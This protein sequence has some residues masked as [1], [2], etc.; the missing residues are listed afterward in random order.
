MRDLST[1][2][3]LE[4]GTTSCPFLSLV[5]EMT[6][7]KL[8]SSCPSYNIVD[9]CRH[10]FS[11]QSCCSYVMSA[12]QCLSLL[13]M[14]YY[15]VL[16]QAK[17]MQ[18]ASLYLLC[19]PLQQVCAERPRLWQQWHILQLTF[20]KKVWAVSF[21]RASGLGCWCMRAR[22]KGL[23]VPILILRRC[24]SFLDNAHTRRS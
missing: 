20:A 21:R 19:L 1:A 4:H 8:L 9:M 12:R 18:S 6:C 11:L 7:L 14:L 5:S 3:L 16:C 23:M 10:A 22:K 13:Y 17:L 15:N 24:S 2:W